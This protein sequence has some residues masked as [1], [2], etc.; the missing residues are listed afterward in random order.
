ML[1]AT[2]KLWKRGHINSYSLKIAIFFSVVFSWVILLVF[3]VIFLCHRFC[4][5]PDY[6][7]RLTFSKEKRKENGVNNKRWS[8]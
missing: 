2:S 7:A 5:I 6:L 4:E 3:E 1:P 8:L